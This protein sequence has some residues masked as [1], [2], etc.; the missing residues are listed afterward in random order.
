[1]EGLKPPSPMSLEGDVGVNFRKWKQQFEMFMLA[2]GLDVKASVSSEQKVAIL[3]HSI[4][5]EVYEIYTTL[6]LSDEERKSWK[7]VLK[8]LEVYFKPKENETINRH[9]FHTRRQKDGESIDSFVTDLKKLAQ[10]CNF[11]DVKDSL[12]RDIIV[13][14]VIDHKVRDALLRE[15]E[16]DL[17]KCVDMCRAAELANLQSKQIGECG[18]QIDAV[19][20]KPKYKKDTR[21]D[22]HG[23]Q[24][25]CKACGLKHGK[26]CPAFRKMCHKC[27]QYNHFAVMCPSNVSSSS[28][29]KAKVYEVQES[30]SELE[31]TD[32]DEMF[33]GMVKKKED[34]VKY[35]NGISEWFQK[36][37]VGKHSINCKVD[38]GADV[39]IL[40]LK[41]A[42]DLN[43]YVRPSKV[44]LKSYNDSK[45]DVVGKTTLECRIKEKKYDVDFQVVDLDAPC[46]IGLP[47]IEKFQLLKKVH[48]VEQN[49][50][51]YLTLLSCSDSLHERTVRVNMTR[52]RFGVVFI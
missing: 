9:M 48:A 26:V 23:K 6:E 50:V 19:S 36:I 49:N 14:G 2:S 10:S 52:Q 18:S 37:N 33:V 32:G 12:I 4:G 20:R 47:F 24:S 42:K 7:E 5:S 39:N 41:V 31:E 17:K 51:E 45:I 28:S 8:K 11:G 38:T 16:L 40:N 3:L 30:S 43:L 13:C 35:V 29:K 21:D 25:R 44:K 22:H 34:N 46:I 1:M 27:K 15:T